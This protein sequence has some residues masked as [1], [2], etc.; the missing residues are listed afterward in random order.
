MSELL[1]IK[2]HDD[3]AWMQQAI[4]LAE[5]AA[6]LGEVPVG[7]VLIY[8]NRL[9]GQGF[10]HS[11]GKHDPTAHAEIMALRE[12]GQHL[13][14]YRLLNTTLYVTLEPCAMCAGAIIHSRIG[15]LVYGATDKKTGA[16]GSLLD[17]IR[18]PG[19][20]H[21]LT[22]TEGVLRETCSSQ[23]SQF[24]RHRRAEIKQAKKAA[25]SAE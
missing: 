4:K 21:S 2:Q 23:L 12:G 6:R 25:K 13:G 17:V 3:E 7:A 16:V 11:I 14:N 15:R 24:F 9:I 1:S 18:H 8:Q 20:N 19:V 10:N 22:I 5:H